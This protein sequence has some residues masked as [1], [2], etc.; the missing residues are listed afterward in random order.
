MSWI[1]NKDTSFRIEDL[2]AGDEYEIEIFPRTIFN[3]AAEMVPVTVQLLKPVDE[4]KLELIEIRGNRVILEWTQVADVTGA[5]PLD[6][7]SFQINAN[8]PR[9]WVLD[10]FLITRASSGSESWPPSI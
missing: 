5:R 3:N 2:V 10:R 1:R 6:R 4:M 9:L 7:A 8:S